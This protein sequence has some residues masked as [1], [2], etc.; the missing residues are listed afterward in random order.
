MRSGVAAAQPLHA[1]W[2]VRA[3]RYRN[4]AVLP[5]RWCLHTARYNRTLVITVYL[6][7]YPPR[8]TGWFACWQC[9]AAYHFVHDIPYAAA[10]MR[11]GYW[12]L[13]YTAAT[14]ALPL[15]MRA[16]V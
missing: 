10:L 15:C 16:Y 5:V 14:L 4:A 11:V 1:S 9:N 13:F 12:L 8:I 3:A 6:P 7:V 2:F